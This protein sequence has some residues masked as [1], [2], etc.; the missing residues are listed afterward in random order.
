MKRL[1]ILVAAVAS[2]SLAACGSSSSTPAPQG[3]PQPAGTVAVNFTVDDT[4]NRLFQADELYWK[5][6]MI[7]DPT[8]RKI[9]FDSTWGGPWAPLYD[10]G[11]WNVDPPGHEPAGSVAGDHKWGVTVFATPGAAATTYEYGLVDHAFGDGWIWVGNNGS[12][13][14]AAGAT[15]P[16]TATGLTIAPF[17]NIDLRFTLDTAALDTQGGTV[18]WDTSVVQV[19]GGAWAWNLINMYDDGTHG[20]ATA[21]DGI[22]TFVLSD[23]VGAGKTYFH[24]GLLKSGDQPQ[25]VF[26]FNGVEYRDG[27]GLPT[28]TGAVA[29]T[30]APGGAWTARTVVP[31]GNDNNNSI[32]VP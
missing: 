28:A 1:M 18:T 11:P 14:V 4:A 24:T 20:D 21:G 32:V 27:A 13:V 8:T 29:E 5:G 10:D 15:T 25:F 23:W 16:I 12:F 26:V 17:G 19:K 9:T 2:V 7:Y 30:M 6:A 3:F 22:Y 31:F